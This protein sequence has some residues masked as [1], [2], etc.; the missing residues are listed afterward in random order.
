[1]D[2]IADDAYKGQYHNFIEKL[3]DLFKLEETSLLHHPEEKI[4]ILIF[5][6]H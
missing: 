6:F 2:H 5:T 3:A 4:V 1:M